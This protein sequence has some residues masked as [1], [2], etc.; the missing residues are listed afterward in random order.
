MVKV[1]IW[2]LDIS[3]GQKRRIKASKEEEAVD[4]PNY[5]NSLLNFKNSLVYL[6]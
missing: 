3:L 5:V 1:F 4:L 2:M 6:N